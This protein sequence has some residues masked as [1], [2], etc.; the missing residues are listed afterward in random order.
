MCDVKRTERNVAG[1]TSEYNEDSFRGA[2]A[3]SCSIRPEA[4]VIFNFPI[5]NTDSDTVD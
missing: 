2:S 1:L 5:Q 4:L 3:A